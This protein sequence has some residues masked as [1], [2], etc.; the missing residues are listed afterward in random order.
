M[1]IFKNI[2]TSYY[3]LWDYIDESQGAFVNKK[4]E[5]VAIV[6]MCN[7]FTYSI[8]KHF[9]KE[10]NDI[11]LTKEDYF[12]LYP[13]RAKGLTFAEDI[14]EYEY[15]G[16]WTL[17]YILQRYDMEKFDK[18]A[19]ILNEIWIPFLM[20]PVEGPWIAP[21]DISMGEKKLMEFEKLYENIVGAPKIGKLLSENENFKKH[22][23]FRLNDLAFL[24]STYK[25]YDDV[26]SNE[27]AQKAFEAYL[28][29]EAVCKLLDVTPTQ[30]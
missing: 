4:G 26:A 6:D 23:S 27:Y 12:R 13:K 14:P 24:Y 21:D 1:N 28:K 3:E 5:I 17:G 19:D 2:R 9:F 10:T 15:D 30:A 8:L 7:P 29:F 25:E 22:L 20:K 16:T 11:D 18:L